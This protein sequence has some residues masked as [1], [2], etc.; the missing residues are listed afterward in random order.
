MKDPPVLKH[1][2]RDQPA[3]SAIDIPFIHAEAPRD[4]D[5][6]REPLPPDPRHHRHVSLGDLEATSISR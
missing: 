4:L 3:Q 1:P 2:E 5:R 6:F